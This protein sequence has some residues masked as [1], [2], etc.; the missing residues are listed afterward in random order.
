[1][2]KSARIYIDG[3]SRGNPGHCGA[4]VVVCNES[5]EILEKYS[6]YIGVGTNNQAEYRALLMAFDK[7]RKHRFTTVKIY[8]D[9]EILFKQL[10]GKY[11]VRD[12]KLKKL[13]TRVIKEM[14]AYKN[15][16]YEWIPR[17]M[18]KIADKL[19]QKAINLDLKKNIMQPAHCPHTYC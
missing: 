19:S 6:K 7:I 15:V 1:M 16:N 17:Q 4:G 12:E 9:S 13:F 5:G 2:N 18:N 14:H 10:T 3:A 8:T 11:R